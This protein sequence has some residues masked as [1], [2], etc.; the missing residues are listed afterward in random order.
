M[1]LWRD[2]GVIFLYTLSSE[3]I[4]VFTAV[5]VVVAV[6]VTLVTTIV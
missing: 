3:L 4:F 5:V 6:I 2:K 1:A